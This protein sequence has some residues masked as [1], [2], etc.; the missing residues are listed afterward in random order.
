M[1]TEPPS[2]RS[3]PL[4][5][6]VRS[7][8]TGAHAHLALRRGNVLRYR[9]GIA[10]FFCMPDEPTAQDWADVAA[11]SDPAE[12]PLAGVVVAPPEEWAIVR[13]GPGL[14]LVGTGIDG[15]AEGIDGRADDGTGRLEPADLAEIVE[16]VA[17]NRNGRVFAP[18][19]LELGTYLGIR[20]RGTLVAMA[21][22][23]LHPQGWTEISSVCTDAAHRRQG[24]ATRLVGAVVAGIRERGEAPFLHVAEDN[25]AALRVY[26]RL[27]FR[28]RRRISMA[29][30][31][32]PDTA[33]G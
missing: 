24:L 33:G 25:D 28:L 4:D 13:R 6:P 11:L 7:S 21:G 29:T 22:E 8:L 30:V 31:R 26:R 27:G 3:H 23:R 5:D 1:S 16:F 15:R 32:I 9:H 17:R 19:T 18:G 12:A 2:T 20:Q 10:R 14:Q